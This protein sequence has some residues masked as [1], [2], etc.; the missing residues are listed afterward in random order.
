MSIKRRIGFLK[1]Y[2]HRKTI[3]NK[4]KKMWFYKAYSLFYLFIFM[5]SIMMFIKLVEN[6][7]SFIQYVLLSLFVVG[8]VIIDAVIRES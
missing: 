3:L 8:G 1:T 6:N 5:S 2:D 7:G 4:L